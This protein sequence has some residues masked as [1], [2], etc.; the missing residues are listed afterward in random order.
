MCSRIETNVFCYGN[1]RAR[2]ITDKDREALVEEDDD[3]D[4]DEDADSGDETITTQEVAE[5]PAMTSITGVYKIVAMGV[6][7]VSTL[8]T[9]KANEYVI[10]V[11]REGPLGL[12]LVR[13]VFIAS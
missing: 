3:E 10:S 4:A 11:R 5:H 1:S 7:S 12:Q 6:V 13:F 8:V 2:E 9:A